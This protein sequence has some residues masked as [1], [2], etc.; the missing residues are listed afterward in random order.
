MRFDRSLQDAWT[1][2]GRTW[3][4]ELPSGWM[5]GRSIFGGLSTAIAAGL[6]NRLVGPP[7]CL[8]TFTVQFLRPLVPGAVSST[9]RSLREGKSVRFSQVE[10]LQAGESALVV[11]TTH[12]RPRGDRTAVLAPS[13]TFEKPATALADLPYAEGIVPE[14]TQ[15]VAMRW[16]SGG[17]PFMGASDARFSGY[18]RFRE[19]AADVEGMVG[20]LDVWPCPSLSVLKKPAF[21]SSVSWTAHILKVPEP[22]PEWFGFEYE[23]VA[24]DGGFHTAVGRLYGDDGE[25]I[26]WTEQ[27]VVVFA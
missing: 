21:A 23:T 16:A 13:R 12:V 27:L 24:G 19:A 4:S 1:K 14:F 5:Q 25:L 8:R 9:F 18:C 22:F 6:A 15:R 10:L 11:N 26:G 3:T 2:D 7:W 20:L 17:Y